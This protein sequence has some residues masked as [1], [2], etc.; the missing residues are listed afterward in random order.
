MYIDTTQKK[1]SDNETEV[2]DIHTRYEEYTLPVLIGI[3]GCIIVGL[4]VAIIVSKP[5]KEDKNIGHVGTSTQAIA[6]HV[7]TAVFETLRLEA[8]SVLVFDVREGNALYAKKA[9]T[10]HPLASI[11]KVMTALV[12]ADVLPED[13]IITITREHLQEEGNSGLRIGERWKRDDLIEH[14]LIVSSNDAARALTDAYENRYQV[15]GPDFV[16][17]MNH[18]AE[19]LG[20]RETFFLNESG[21]DIHDEQFAGSAGSAEDVATLFAYAL[22][23]IPELLDATRHSSQ[24]NTSLDTVHTVDNTNTII[25]SIPWAVGSKTGFTDVAGGNL[26]IA[27]DVSIGRPI[28]IVVLGSSKEGRFFDMQQLVD[29]TVQS[30]LEL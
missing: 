24:V 20:L 10:P 19:E 26:V 2:H 6:S 15:L 5:N 1:E 16:T 3:V 7:D 11:T 27:F 25:D 12:A 23:T 18:K 9:T 29:A 21:L 14:L 22:K 8:E 28:I 17:L 13:A 4:I 30:F